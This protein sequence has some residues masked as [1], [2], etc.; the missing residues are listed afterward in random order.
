MTQ[1]AT[2]RTDATVAIVG[3]RR[4]TVR[5]DGTD[6]AVRT[7]DRTIAYECHTAGRIEDEWT[8]VPV[9][10]LLAAA[11]APGRTTHVTVEAWDGLVAC[12]PL[13]TALEGMLAFQ[14]AENRL[15]SPRFL[16]PGIAGPR[17]VRDVVCVEAVELAP[18]EDRHAYE[19]L[20]PATG[21][22]ERT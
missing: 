11:A 20:A 15:P 18:A 13:T 21:S 1:R 12:V 17:A 6:S 7:V 2:T 10:E 16:A 3:E 19:N 8:G 5:V 4:A 22:G 14:R 9:V